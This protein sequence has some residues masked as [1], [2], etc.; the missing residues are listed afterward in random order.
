MKYTDVIGEEIWV[1][2]LMKTKFYTSDR[3]TRKPYFEKENEQTKPCS[4]Y[5]RTAFVLK[6]DEQLC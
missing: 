4:G 3:K 1:N 2:L 6:G 5:Q